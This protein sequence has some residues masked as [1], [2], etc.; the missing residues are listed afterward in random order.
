MGKS[1]TKAP[2]S[3][4]RA[5]ALREAGSR[6]EAEIEAILDADESDIEEY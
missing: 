1:K 4:E 6:E 5:D 2:T 3:K